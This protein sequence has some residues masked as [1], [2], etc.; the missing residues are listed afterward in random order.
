MYPINEV[1]NG[2]IIKTYSWLGSKLKGITTDKSYIFD[3]N[4]RGIRERKLIRNGNVPISDIYYFYDSQNRLVGESRYG[5]S[6]TGQKTKTSDIIY[7][8]DATGLLYGFRYN[9]VEYYYDRDILGNINHIIHN[10]G[11]IVA[12][13]KYEAY[14]KH[15]VLNASGVEVLNSTFIG[16]INP[17]RYKGYY[18]DVE[19]QLFYCNSRYYNP[20]WGRWISPDSIEYLD[21]SSINGLNLYS[22]CHNNPV[23]YSDGSGHMPEWLK[24]V[25]DIGL[26]IVSAAISIAVG[27]AVSKVA[28][29]AAGI[30]AGIAV[31]GALNN[32]TNTIYYN[33]ISDG[34]S[35]LTSS[36]YRNGYIN[37]WDR[38]DY[39]KQQT[40]Q[41]KFNAISWMY[42]SEYNLHMYGWYL[43]GWAHENNIPLISDIAERTYA[44]EINVGKWDSRWYVNIGIVIIG[45]LG[46]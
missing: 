39:V 1:E 8:Y 31:F 40:G 21:P 6:S 44:A 25:L 19:T 41:E 46:L 16:N 22:Y 27:I 28:T 32:L 17:I 23:M 7:I 2:S 15:K 20:E 26:Y 35:D 10:N 4:A 11:L 30:V 13:Y 42:F 14:G 29:P 38:L 9:G 12:T 18:Y 34:E 36:S 37:R 24:I 33:F 45:L 43:T 5:Y 3:Y